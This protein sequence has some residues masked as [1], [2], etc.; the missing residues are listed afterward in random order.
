MDA[1]RKTATECRGGRPTKRQGR[2]ACPFDALP[3]DLARLIGV[4][5]SEDPDLLALARTCTRMHRCTVGS[6][7]FWKERFAS[8]GARTN[9]ATVGADA[10]SSSV[11]AAW[12]ADY[13]RYRHVPVPC[14]RGYCV[15]DPDS[16][17]LVSLALRRNYCD[18]T[19][20]TFFVL[21]LRACERCVH[22]SDGFASLPKKKCA[23]CYVRPIYYRK[24]QPRPFSGGGVYCT[25]HTQACDCAPGTHMRI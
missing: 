8:L 15:Q 13:A 19:L 5:V 12:T 10:S 22:S 9:P 2:A 1:K 7:T 16:D 14:F 21:T 6:G 23:A 24:D 20:G 11:V 25:G 17:V 18:E 4:S 3:D